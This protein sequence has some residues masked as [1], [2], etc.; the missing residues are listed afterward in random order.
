MSS[1]A[2]R[3]SWSATVTPAQGSALPIY[4]VARKNHMNGLAQDGFAT[5]NTRAGTSSACSISDSLAAA[6]SG[7]GEALPHATSPL[8]TAGAAEAAGW[9]GAA[10][11]G[12][13]TSACVEAVDGEGVAKAAAAAL[14]DFV[15]A[16]DRPLAAARPCLVT[17]EPVARLAGRFAER[18]AVRWAERLVVGLL[19]APALFVAFFAGRLPVFVLRMVTAQL[20]AASCD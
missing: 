3:S 18:L 17:A 4:D 10:F 1:S 12:A 16:F 2:R 19:E 13:G 9:L 6:G 7:A 20:A 8:A 5:H 15:A 14:A 11:A